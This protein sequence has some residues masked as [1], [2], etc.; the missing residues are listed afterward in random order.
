MT[1]GSSAPRPSVVACSAAKPSAAGTTATMR[2]PTVVHSTARTTP[3]TS[4]PSFMVA[5]SGESA[6]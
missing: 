2:D 5:G 4:A 3:G 1:M 6:L